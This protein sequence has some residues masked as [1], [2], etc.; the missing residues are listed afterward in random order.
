[1]LGFPWLH[2]LINTYYFLS[3]FAIVILTRLRWYFSVVF[4]CMSLMISDG[5]HL[6]MSLLAIGISSLE[7][8]LFRS[9]ILLTGLFFLFLFDIELY[10]FF[11]YL[12]STS[13]W[14]L[15]TF[16][17][18]LGCIFVL[19]MVSFAVQKFLSLIRSYFFFL[20]LFTIP[21]EIDT[22]WNC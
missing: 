8:C 17:H 19:F 4:T 20:L 15:F 14:T 7:K 9:S 18:S 2:S 13:Y 6:F 22:K 16:F 1:M 12:I 5:D 21:K 10:D 11:I 3:F